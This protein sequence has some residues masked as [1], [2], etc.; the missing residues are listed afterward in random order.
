MRGLPRSSIGT[1]LGLALLGVGMVA[2]KR[3]RDGASIADA[4][5]RAPS[6]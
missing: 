1:V 5:V 6:E 3:T 4:K 2:A